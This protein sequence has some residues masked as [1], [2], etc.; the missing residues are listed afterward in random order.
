MWGP[1]VAQT[2]ES[3]CS[4]GDPGS[5]PGS[6][7]T[8]T[9][10]LA[11]LT[12]ALARKVGGSNEQARSYLPALSRVPHVARG[13]ARAAQDTRAAPYVAHSLH[14]HVRGDRKSTRL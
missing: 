11:A 8:R 13:C 6:P 3:A 5:I 14:L 4:L 2:V 12:G 1:L 9:A 10:P 7:F